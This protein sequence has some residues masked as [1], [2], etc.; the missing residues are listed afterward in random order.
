VANFKKALFGQQLHCRANGGAADL[1]Q[2]AQASFA[3]K[4]LAPLVLIEGFADRGGRLD[5]KRRS[6]W[7]VE[8]ARK[9]VHS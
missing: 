5:R 3:W 1:E 9:T 4:N 6:P 2:F 7:Q 8:R